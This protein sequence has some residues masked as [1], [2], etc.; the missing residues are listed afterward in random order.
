MIRDNTVE[1][2]LRDFLPGYL[3]LVLRILMDIGCALL[4]T[5]GMEPAILPSRLCVSHF[6]L[7]F[8]FLTLTTCCFTRLIGWFVFRLILQ[9]NTVQKYL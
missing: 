6:R 2:I 7:P 5:F 4:S 3:F 9:A 8:S 1:E